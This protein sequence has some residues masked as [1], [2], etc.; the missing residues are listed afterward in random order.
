MS[1][2]EDDDRVMELDDDMD[3][4][5]IDDDLVGVATPSETRR[6]LEDKLEE[7]RLKKLTQDYD[8]DFDDLD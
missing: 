6:K 7:L 5:E 2:D 8:F 1:D 4:E 3:E